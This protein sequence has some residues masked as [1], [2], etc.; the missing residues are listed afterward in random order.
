MIVFSIS[1]RAP[2][3]GATGSPLHIQCMYNIS[4]HAP[5]RGATVYPYTLKRYQTDFNPRSREGSDDFSGNAIP[6]QNISI[7]APA[8][9]ATLFRQLTQN[10]CRFQSTLPRGERPGIFTHWSQTLIFQSALPRGERPGQCTSCA[11]NEN[12][13]PRSREG[14]DVVAM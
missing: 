11:P 5:A 2:A 6:G 7:H 13:N 14:S 10:D 4:I 1:I 12:F 3:R 8:R 9:G